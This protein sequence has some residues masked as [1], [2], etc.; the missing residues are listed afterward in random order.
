MNDHE[1]RRTAELAQAIK[2]VAAMLS[3]PA[4]REELDMKARYRRVKYDSHIAAGFSA[5]QA[6]WLCTQEG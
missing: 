3:T 4:V 2:K 6:L 1:E 5:G